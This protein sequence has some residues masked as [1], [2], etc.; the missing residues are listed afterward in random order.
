MACH[1]EN[2]IS[3]KNVQNVRLSGPHTRIP[4]EMFEAYAADTDTLARTKIIELNYT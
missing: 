3:L 2:I 4:K 1:T